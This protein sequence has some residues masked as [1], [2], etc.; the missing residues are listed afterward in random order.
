M[1]YIFVSH[2]LSTKVISVSTYWAFEQSDHASVKIDFLL[3][4]EVTTG[5]GLTKINTTIMD[6]AVN[7]VKI[8]SSIIE[9]LS[10]IPPGY[11]QIRLLK[12]PICTDTNYFRT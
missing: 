11:D 4:E 10:Q 1:S 9:M 8:R 5:P 12:S 2:Y 6:D 3:H 7:A